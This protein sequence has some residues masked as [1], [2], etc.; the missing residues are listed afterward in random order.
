MFTSQSS[1]VSYSLCRTA[2]TSKQSKNNW[3][4]L[5]HKTDKL[6]VRFITR[7]HLVLPCSWLASFNK[8]QPPVSMAHLYLRGTA[9]IYFHL[10]VRKKL[11]HTARFE[12]I[13]AGLL[14][15]QA[16]W[17]A[18][19]CRMWSMYVVTYVASYTAS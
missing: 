1:Y 17:D 7:P 12:F 16:S 5:R 3:R 15:I 10:L 9:R 6:H 4:N 2:G 18:V 11:H 14:K 13:T 19:S 8:A